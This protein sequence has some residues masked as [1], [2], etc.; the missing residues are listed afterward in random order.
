MKKKFIPEKDM[1]DVILPFAGQWVTL[2]SDKTKV[3]GH[4]K[5]METALNQAY[6]KGESTPHLIKSPDSSTS[7]FIF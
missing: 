4:S 2:S 1:A 7:V 6:K 5:K 3:L